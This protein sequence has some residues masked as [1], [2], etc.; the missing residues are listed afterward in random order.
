MSASENG[1]GGICSEAD[2]NLL[3]VWVWGESS[4]SCS[5][6]CHWKSGLVLVQ[7]EVVAIDT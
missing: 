4:L 7:L 6:C 2:W 3:G 5:S 1:L